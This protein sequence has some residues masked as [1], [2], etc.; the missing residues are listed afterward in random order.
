M[1]QVILIIAFVLVG[2]GSSYAAPD[3]VFK[4]SR[5]ERD[6][7]EKKEEAAYV[8]N[9]VGKTDP[10]APF[11]VSAEQGLTGTQEKTAREGGSEWQSNMESILK[12]L[13]EPKT[14][15]QRIDIS[16]LK[17]TSVI[18]GKD[19]A[20]AMVSDKEGRGYLIQ[21]G[22]YIGTNG[23]IV[24]EIIC[25]DKQTSFGIEAIRKITI[26]EPFFNQNKELDY[27]AVEMKMP[28]SVQN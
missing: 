17:L 8:Y 20:W 2:S 11:I 5:P 24:D 16:D 12:D 23:G 22:T 21:K 6:L 25:E 19:K 18:K 1:I 3:V 9:P 28:L 27:K 26:K 14:E 13:K 10:F 7:T 4:D 15:L